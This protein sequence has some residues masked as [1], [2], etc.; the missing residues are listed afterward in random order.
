M[1]PDIYE[2]RPGLFCAVIP[3]PNNP[4]KA[5][6]CYI[7]LDSERTL[8]IDMG[9]DLPVCRE[10]LLYALKECG[11]SW[12]SVQ[13]V[14]T[15]SHPDH[16]GLLD[17][18]AP[19]GSP[20]LAGFASIEDLTSTY[21]AVRDAAPLLLDGALLDESFCQVRFSPCANVP[22]QR[23]VEGDEIAAGRYRFQV[24]ETPG[25]D[26][27]HICLCDASA[28]VMLVGD[29]VLR[30]I[31]PSVNVFTPHRD[32]LGSYLNNLQR[33][34]ATGALTALPGHGRPIEDVRAEV[35]RIRTY[36]LDKVEEIYELVCQGFDDPESIAARS[37]G[38][39]SCWSHQHPLRRIWL[40]TEVMAYLVKLAHDGRVAISCDASGRYLFESC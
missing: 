14:A 16:I 40:V 27:W 38:L 37:S 20:V 18:L 32:L 23:V 9:F 7:V 17:S 3:F 26:E 39:F 5:V 31:V 35:D 12:E 10:A 24:M 6:N 22:V 8:V 25:H 36:Y 11:R 29:H 33:M 4:L 15:H 2:V 30:K 28:G 19:V 13:V 21:R 1:R 34:P